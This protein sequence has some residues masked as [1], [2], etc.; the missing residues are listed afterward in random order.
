MPPA[1]RPRS[2]SLDRE[3]RQQLDELDALMQR[4]L[5]L[6]VDPPDDLANPPIQQ[7]DTIS[8]GT[9]AP[10]E[11]GP[12]AAA[13]LAPEPAIP[14]QVEEPHEKGDSP[15]EDRGTAPFF[16]GQSEPLP[17]AADPVPLPSPS[18]RIESWG[19]TSRAPV[20][21][22]FAGLDSPRSVEVKLGKSAGV[23]AENSRSRRVAWPVYPL[24]WINWTF[25]RATR[26]LGPLGRWLRGPGGRAL[27]GWGGLL[28]LAAALVW[29]AWDGLGWTW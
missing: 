4:M 24:L 5:A 26:L 21:V 17:P 14:V 25:D 2:S 16:L 29:L 22:P 28:L 23:S 3:T 19:Y 18:E 12:W 9:S 10:S 20:V 15:L 13:A 6:P 7:P 1:G 8:E 27:L 11:A